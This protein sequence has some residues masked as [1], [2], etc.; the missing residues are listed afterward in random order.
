MPAGTPG[1][2]GARLR[3]AREARA[4]TA[5]ALSEIVGV[6][7]ASI[8]QY[9]SGEHSPR[10]EVMEL[11]A[12]ALN[13]PM[14]FFFTPPL[15]PEEGTVFF[16]SMSAATKTA[17]TRAERR[18]GW[19]QES[20]NVIREYVQFPDHD[21]PSLDLP[22]DYRALTTHDIEMAAVTCRRYWGLGD[23]PIADVTALME[24]HGTFV[25]R[26]ALGVETLDALSVWSSRDRCPY[27]LLGADKGSAVRSRWDEC[28]EAG[29]L[30]L[31][32]SVSKAVLRNKTEFRRL[33]DQ[34][35]RFAG[36]MLLPSKSFPRDVYLPGLDTLLALKPKWKVAIAAMLKRLTDLE[37]VSEWDARRLWINYVRRGW[38]GWEPLDDSLPVEE[39]S[40]IRNAIEFMM[41]DVDVAS[42]AARFPVHAAEAE[43]MVGL[44]SQ[45]TGVAPIVRFR[46]PDKTTDVTPDK[47]GD[48]VQF[49]GSVSVSD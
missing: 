37:L 38:R 42:V 43:R 7:S 18:L 47:P 19:F 45:L 15:E 36:A 17:R 4:I 14:Q 33:E 21:L 23:Y 1:F 46:T 48:V 9:E 32:R 11:I 44:R 29:H 35:H 41:P 3:E 13:M 26:D 22:S 25:M 27:I 31:H 40:L 39:P 8:T 49:P 12:N 16:R 20:V 24:S 2:F 5:M 34:A 30:F 6:K 28:H 10:P